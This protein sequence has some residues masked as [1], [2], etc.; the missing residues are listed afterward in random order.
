MADPAVSL[1][2]IRKAA[3]RSGAKVVALTTRP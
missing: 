1:R 2:E 3:R